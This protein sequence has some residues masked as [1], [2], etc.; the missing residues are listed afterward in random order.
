MDPTHHFLGVGHPLQGC[1]GHT[2]VIKYHKIHNM[3]RSSHNTCNYYVKMVL[4]VQNE[5][6]LM[7]DYVCFPFVPHTYLQVFLY[8]QYLVI[9][10]NLVS[11]GQYSHFKPNHHNKCTSYTHNGLHLSFLRLNSFQGCRGHGGAIICISSHNRH[12]IFTVSLE[13][14]LNKIPRHL[15]QCMPNSLLQS[16]QNMLVLK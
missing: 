15:H 11:F 16:T 5:S 6:Y 3:Y 14:C 2:E 7:S 10:Y 9:I 4:G 8:V 13:V 12:Q 1:R